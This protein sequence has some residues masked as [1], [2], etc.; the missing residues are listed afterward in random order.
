MGNNVYEHY[1][2][3]VNCYWNSMA[4]LLEKYGLEHMIL[5]HLSFGYIYSNAELD[6]TF[7]L[8]AEASDSLGWLSHYIKIKKSKVNTENLSEFL[9]ENKDL[10]LLCVNIEALSNEYKSFPPVHDYHYLNVIGVE[11]DSVR[12][13]DQYFGYRGLM[14]INLIL[15]AVESDSI[16]QI[17]EVIQLEVDSNNLKGKIDEITNQIKGELLVKT[18]QY[19]EGSFIFDDT[20]NL[21]GEKAIER[22]SEELNE[23]ISIIMERKESI[24]DNWNYLLRRFNTCFIY[25]REGIVYYLNKYKDIFLYNVSDLI[26]DMEASLAITRQMSFLIIQANLKKK[27]PYNLAKVFKQRLEDVIRIERKI[28]N[29]VYLLNRELKAVNT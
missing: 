10:F 17:G 23:V 24:Q 28:H 25:S 5:K 15:K 6:I 8:E 9:N 1:R 20:L 16:V 2:R 27:D 7:E 12:V 14:P 22:F 11:N 26:A 19:L 29:Q 21:V 18:D 4:L 3:G 13:E